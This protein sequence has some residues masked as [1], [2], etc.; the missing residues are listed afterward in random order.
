MI[1]NVALFAI[2]FLSSCAS[3]PSL[4]DNIEKIATDDAI[5][6]K[7]DRDAFKKETDVSVN[8][9]VKNKDPIK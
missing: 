6:V 1:K 5:T 2:F 3:M 8:V 7:V 9:E 4:F